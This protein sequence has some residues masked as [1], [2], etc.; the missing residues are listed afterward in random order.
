[1][2][3]P[4]PGRALV[5][6]LLGAVA[7]PLVHVQMSS[8]WPMAASAALLAA[9]L[10]GLL[11]VIRGR[12][13][14]WW[15]APLAAGACFA[16]CGLRAGAYLADGLDPAL[17]TDD[18]VLVG[19]VAGLPQR[20]DLGQRFRFE[21]EDSRRRE[22]RP[23]QVPPLVSLAWYSGAWAAGAGA[24]DDQRAAPV[25]QAGERWRFTARLRVPRGTR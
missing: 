14:P 12:L 11:L 8:L 5:P 17:E 10:P 18:L 19:I 3:V 15:L 24:G 21:V 7:G 23:V 9:C 25:L 20:N 2:D 13:S 6:L 4:P 1:M 16:A 22:G